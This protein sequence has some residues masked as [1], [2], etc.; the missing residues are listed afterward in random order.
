MH[1]L[2]DLERQIATRDQENQNLRN[3]VGELENRR[4]ILSQSLEDVSQEIGDLEKKREEAK[5]IEKPLSVYSIYGRRPSARSAYEH[6]R[7]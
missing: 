1:T 3:E 6:E 2:A 4:H 7:G 5:A